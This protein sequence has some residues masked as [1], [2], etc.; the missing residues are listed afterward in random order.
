MRIDGNQHV[1]LHHAHGARN[2][3]SDKLQG[4]RAKASGSLSSE[5]QAQQSE[6]AKELV[7]RLQSIATV[8]TE[9]VAQ[10]QQRLTEGVY[11]GPAAAA[12]TADAIFGASEGS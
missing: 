7:S 6:L 12:R 3:A 1:R 8:R 10:V 9:R 2:P 4:T 11:D 5:S